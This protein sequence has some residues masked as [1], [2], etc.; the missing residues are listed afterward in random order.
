[1]MPQKRLLKSQRFDW[2]DWTPSGCAFCVGPALVVVFGGWA[3]CHGE[4]NSQV[5][6]AGMKMTCPHHLLFHEADR[7]E[8]TDD[9]RTNLRRRLCSLNL[10]SVPTGPYPF[11]TKDAKGDDKWQ[12]LYFKGQFGGRYF[13]IA[14]MQTHQPL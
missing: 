2:V 12:I 5:K 14:F 11:K 7:S 3:C 1:M 10:S 9:Q 4:L 8:W 6:M 13:G